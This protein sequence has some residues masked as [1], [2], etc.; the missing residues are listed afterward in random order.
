M[1]KKIF[2]ILFSRQT[3]LILTFILLSLVVW[4]LGPLVSFGDMYPFVSL[5]SR[6][7]II[8]FLVILL[9]FVIFGWPISVMGIV[10]LC[11]LFWRL[12]PLLAIGEYHFFASIGVRIGVIVFFLFCGLIYVLYRLWGKLR[13]DEDLLNKFFYRSEKEMKNDIEQQARKNLKAVNSIVKRAIAQLRQMYFR[14]GWWRHIFENKRYLYELP[15][16]M[17][18]GNPGAGKTTAI[19]NSGLKFPLAEQMGEAFQSFGKSAVIS[20]EGGTK[21]CDWWFTNEAIMIDTAGRYASQDSD[22]QNDSAEW[23]GFLNLL[24]KYRTQAP[25]NGVILV[26]NVAELINQDK[27]VRMVHAGHLRGRL[28]QLRQKLGIRFPV[29]VIVTKMDMLEGFEQYFSYLTSESRAQVWGFTLP[30]RHHEKKSIFSKRDDSKSKQKLTICLEQHFSALVERLEAGLALRFQE[31]FDLERRR[32]LYA[33]PLEF[34]SFGQILIPFLDEVF[35]DSPY[36]ATQLHNTLRG[37]YFTS[38]LQTETV[39]RANPNTILQRLWRNLRGQTGINT[40]VAQFAEEMKEG[41]DFTAYIPAASRP[42]QSVT[43]IQGYFLGELFSR[44]IFPEASLVRLNLKRE[45]RHRA[46]RLLGHLA[47]FGVLIWLTM[48]LYVSFGSNSEYLKAVSVHAEELHGKLL[49]LFSKTAAEREKYIPESLDAARNLSQF[50]DVDVLEPPAA[51]RYGLYTPPPIVKK[52]AEIY[53]ILQEKLLLPYMIQRLEN[54]LREAVRYSDEKLAYNTLRVY[55]QL[56]DRERYKA[57]DIRAWL[58]KDW[59]NSNSANEF[60]SQVI[61]M[62]HLH[63]LFSDDRVV[64]SPFPINELLVRQ[65][66]VFLD[67]KPSPQRLYERAKEEMSKEAPPDFTLIQTVGPQAG[68]VFVRASGTPLDQGIPGLFTFDGYRRLFDKRLGE[69]VNTV[70]ADDFWVMGRRKVGVT[71]SV[72][73]LANDVRFSNSRSFLTDDSLM[74]DLRRRYLMEYVNQWDAFLEDI[75][76]VSGTSLSFDLVVVQKIAMPDSPLTRL[77]RAVVRETTLSREIV[78]NNPEKNALEKAVETFDRKTR[79]IERDLGLLS[80]ARV[81]R[82]IVDNHFAALREIVTGQT[83]VQENK[84]NTHSIPIAGTVGIVNLSSVIGMIN[85]FHNQLFMADI[86]LNASTVPPN[87]LAAAIKLRLDASRLPA[88]LRNIMMALADNGG[89]KIKLG[90]VSILQSQ[91]E[92]QID[93]TLASFTYQIGNPCRNYLDGYYPFANSAHDA[94]IEEFTRLFA[95]GGSADDF[96]QKQLASYVDTGTRPWRYRDSGNMVM[97]DN[98]HAT[99]DLPMPSA[100]NVPTLQGEY[101][102]QLQRYIPNPDV[103]A[104]IQEI[105]GVFFRDSEAKKM[106]WKMDFKI[107]EIDPAIVEF[108]INIDGQVLRYIH[109]PIQ[110]FPVNW[111]GSRGG[112]VAEISANPRV[113]SETSTI[114]AN[115]PWAIFR[116]L[117]RGKIIDTANPERVLVEYDLDGRKALLEI[118]TGGQ[119]NPLSS[120]LL[121]NFK[122]PGV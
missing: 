63:H 31:E 57:K 87:A 13:N 75:R 85:E 56:H 52:S 32:L 77:A 96:F 83:D 117:D 34:A 2:S 97:S 105:R 8:V 3:L 28:L 44:V 76:P 47:M 54:V 108:I 74:Q 88:P 92:I 22:P 82:E 26:V 100:A 118:S 106:T 11:L 49:V 104:Q 121:R 113:R 81:E 39:L 9:L 111:P 50:K 14:D 66:R 36:D 24:R 33:L 30:Y 72:K 79:D 109:G 112:T 10:A 69:F 91:A 7:I 58:Q 51:F 35:L 29:Y 70:W 110:V 114:V 89:E 38:S 93:R 46:L 122:C 61:V 4:F 116:L 12:G 41:E 90:S 120:G 86:A 25:I 21:H 19:L 95:L 99:N 62:K 20:G 98:P 37:V 15:W 42:K 94:S 71:D 40:S 119:K 78:Q 18:I 102:R 80:Q 17:L 23:F 68:M 16:Y 65:A 5:G 1:F 60:T 53:E 115:G 64:Q 59:E 45:T 67:A 6:V 73:E 55:L 107:V 103:F 101:L 48:A 27:S 43:G 84:E